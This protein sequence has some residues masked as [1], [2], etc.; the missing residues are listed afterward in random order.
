MILNPLQDWDDEEDGEWEAPK[1]KNPAYKGAWSAKRI[2]NPKYSGVWVQKKIP[3]P[4]YEKPEA[5]YA[6]DEFA[7]VGFDLWQVKGI[8]HYIYN[9]LP[10]FITVPFFI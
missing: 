4:E 7:F 1:K 5:L 10:I 6:Y 8:I 2:K 9:S 3:N